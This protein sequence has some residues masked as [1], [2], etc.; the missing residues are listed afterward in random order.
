MDS[1]SEIEFPSNFPTTSSTVSVY[2]TSRIPSP[3]PT[4]S[5]PHLSQRYTPQGRAVKNQKKGKKGQKGLLL[6]NPF[7][8]FNDIKRTF[9]ISNC[10]LY[11]YNDKPSLS[12]YSSTFTPFLPDYTHLSLPITKI[13]DPLLLS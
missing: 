5:G 7:T 6:F 4:R 3:L 12:D 10:Q 8:I 11:L 1:Q 13:P 9:L 2:Y